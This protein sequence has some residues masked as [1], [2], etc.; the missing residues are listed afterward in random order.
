MQDQKLVRLPLLGDLPIV[1]GLFRHKNQ[2]TRKSELVI[3][4][5]P[6]VVESDKTWS[7]E[8]HRAT[9]AMDELTHLSQQLSK[10]A[11]KE[12]AASKDKQEK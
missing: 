4:L 1:G 8:L 12:M 3:L 11:E 6:I 9:G 7:D 10:Q 5:R 2:V